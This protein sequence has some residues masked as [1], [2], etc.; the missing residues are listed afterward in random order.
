MR[1][2]RKTV[3]W[4]LALVASL[5]LLAFLTGDSWHGGDGNALAS[6]SQPGIAFSGQGDSGAGS[7][8]VLDCS[9]LGL[10]WPVP[11]GDGDCD[12]F[13]TTLELHCSTLRGQPLE[14]FCLLPAARRPSQPGAPPLPKGVSCRF[15]RYLERSCH[16]VFR[17]RRCPPHAAISALLT[18]LSLIP[19]G[20]RY[21]RAL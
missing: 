13:S 9:T 19:R 21:H 16:P 17:C 11:V 3:T 2:V 18:G 12:G 8:Q 4:A 1:H 7:P 15:S 20:P 14:R 6:D 10:P 5:L